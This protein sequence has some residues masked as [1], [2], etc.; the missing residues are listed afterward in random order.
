MAAVPDRST[1]GLRVTGTWA[2]RRSS[3]LLGQLA[4][5]LF[6]TL[7]LLFFLVR[8]TGDPAIALSGDS[9]D[10]EVLDAIRREHGL[11]QPLWIQ[12]LVYLGNVLRFDLGTSWVSGQAALQVALERVPATL[13]LAASGLLAN[14]LIAI[15]LGTFLGTHRAPWLR[16]SLDGLVFVA[17]GVPGYVVALFLIQLFV[18]E[19]RWLPSTGDEGL[20]SYVLPSLTIA[21]F[22]APKLARVIAVN[23][24]DA[25]QEE[26][27][28]M[29]RAQGAPDGVLVFRHALPNAMLGATALIGAQLAGLVNG[30]IITETIFGWPGVGRLLL[31]SVLLLDFPVV[32]AVVL[33]T[34]VF[35]FMTNWAAD[36]AI[37]LIDPRLRTH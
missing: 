37:E 1:A 29:A 35:V 19:W 3:A 24:Q 28:T 31:E 5:L 22:L 20:L 32:Q 17:Q 14:L 10:P 30:L 9:T 12:Y 33:V 25:L 4:L 8:L 2:L 18:V 36:R 21:A 11:D 34:T 6:V 23:V 15:P 13:V 16:K 27:V 7:T 26:Y